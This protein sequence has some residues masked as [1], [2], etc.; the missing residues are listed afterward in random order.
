LISSKA[1]VYIRSFIE[2]WTSDQHEGTSEAVATTPDVDSPSPVV[3][4]TAVVALSMSAPSTF[5]AVGSP[6]RSCQRG[7]IRGQE[8]EYVVGEMMK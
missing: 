2:S 7:G 1:S 6:K 3:E 4:A 5:I 8:V